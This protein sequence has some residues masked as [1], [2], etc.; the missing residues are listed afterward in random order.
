MSHL[1][2]WILAIITRGMPR[3]IITE[4]LNY[5]SQRQGVIAIAS[6]GQ[7]M[8]RCTVACLGSNAAW[9]LLWTRTL[10]ESH[11]VRDGVCRNIHSCRALAE[12]ICY[13]QVRSKRIGHNRNEWL[14][15]VKK[16]LIVAVNLVHDKREKDKQKREDR[17]VHRIGTEGGR[18]CLHFQ[19][20]QKDLLKSR[21]Y[22]LVLEV[23]QACTCTCTCTSV[24]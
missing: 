5:E 23:I 7:W 6:V 16:H 24:Y 9:G 14:E 15:Y 11:N 22:L 18:E 1:G 20:I 10:F 2:H 3:H 4:L 12:M 19:K 17:K 13:S 21:R 8:D